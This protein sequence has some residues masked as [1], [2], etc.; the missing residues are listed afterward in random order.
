MA[1]PAPNFL[2]GRRYILSGALAG[3]MAAIAL[4]AQASGE[5]RLFEKAKTPKPLPA[6]ISEAVLTQPKAVSGAD[7]AMPTTAH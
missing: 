4:P 3:A 5:M 6:S 7:P 2:P 1:Y